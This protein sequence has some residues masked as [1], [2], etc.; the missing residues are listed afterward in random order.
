MMG[1]YG[2]GW[3]V[4]MWVWMAAFWSLIIAGVVWAVWRAQQP[5]GGAPGTGE[6]LKQRLARGEIDVDEYRAL[7]RELDSEGSGPPRMP[8][9]GQLL[10]ALGVA[11][12]AVTLFAAPAIAVARGDWDMFD[13]M[14]GMMGGGRDSSNAPLTV[15]GQ[16]EAVAISDF[17]FT[18][19][20]LSV[21]V[22]ATV[23][24][25]N[26]DSA[27]HDATSR[28]GSWRTATLSRGETGSVTFDSA[29]EY[30]YFCTIHPSM[31]AHLSVE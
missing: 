25:T 23:S 15:G 1:G 4:L 10:L 18:P 13:H 28:D 21:P 20:N 30:D 22:G 7:A 14:R 5:R 16:D 12:V 11:I 17:A 19:G 29:G 24:W 9:A 8:G 3:W 31:K 26:R 6:I 27:A 2:D